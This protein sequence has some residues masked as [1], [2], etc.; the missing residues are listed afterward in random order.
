MSPWH[1]SWVEAIGACSDVCRAKD[2]TTHL[3]GGPAT[4]RALAHQA[5]RAE[6]DVRAGPCVRRTALEPVGCG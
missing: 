2:L 3:P 6:V 5:D 4:A 1:V